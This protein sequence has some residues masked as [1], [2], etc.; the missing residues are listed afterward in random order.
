MSGVRRSTS[1]GSTLLTAPSR[2]LSLVTS[3]T[4]GPVP[5]MSRA[6]RGWLRLRPRPKRAFSLRRALSEGRAGLG[7]R[8]CLLYG[9]NI[10][11]QSPSVKGEKRGRCPHPPPRLPRLPPGRLLLYC[12]LHIVHNTVMNWPQLPVMIN[13]D[14]GK[15]QKPKSSQ[16][17][18]IPLQHLCKTQHTH[19]KSPGRKAG[20]F[21]FRLWR[22]AF[23]AFER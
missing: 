11:P 12:N 13:M 2:G 6:A 14:S 5:L 4:G 19:P 10:S 8:H 9:D 15:S 20:A 23:L 3:V 18:P 17:K 16:T 22:S 21:W 1:H 7:P